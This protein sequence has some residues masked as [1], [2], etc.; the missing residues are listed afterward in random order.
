MKMQMTRRTT[1]KRRLKSLSTLMPAK[2]TNSWWTLCIPRSGHLFHTLYSRK[3]MKA[4]A[5]KPKKRV[6]K[7]AEKNRRRRM[8]RKT[9]LTLSSTNSSK[10]SSVMIKCTLS[11]CLDW[12]ASW[13]YRWFTNL[14]YLTR[15]L[16]RRLRT[17]KSS[18]KK[19]KN[20]QSRR[21]SGKSNRRRLANRKK[22]RVK[23]TRKK[24]WNGRISSSLLSR[25]SK[26]SIFSV[27]TL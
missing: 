9:L 18:A 16:K 17:I 12:A 23:P 6:A 3:A 26:K 19:W 10:K 8:F 13:Q 5:K 22:K 4:K 24:K 25:H 21:Q 27:L 7:V 20:R 2:A 14:A 1:T 15:H 11:E